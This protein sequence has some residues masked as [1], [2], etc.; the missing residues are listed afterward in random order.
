MDT[1]THPSRDPLYAILAEMA[2]IWTAAS[3]GYYFVLPAL[4]LPTSYNVSP[5]PIAAY[6]LF[7]AIGIGFYFHTHFTSWMH[8]DRRLFVYGA[9]SLSLAAFI[10]VL[11]YYFSLLPPENF[12][13]F[14][15][16]TD[17]LFATPWYF[18]PKAFEILVQQLLITVLVVELARRFVTLAKVELAYAVTFGGAHVVLYFL[19][20]APTFYAAI[21][22]SGAIFSALVFPRLLLR[23][24]GGFVYSYA[25]QL[26]FYIAVAVILHSLPPPGYLTSFGG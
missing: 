5:I 22:T 13:T 18:L 19:N 9:Q 24:R 8:R 26:M 16:Y 15:A 20:G 12:A 1:P 11:L 21:M 23:V 3:L 10:W 7:W 25:I 14:T 6:Y 17:I 4:G 2:V